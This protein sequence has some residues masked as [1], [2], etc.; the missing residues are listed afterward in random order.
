MY[1]RYRWQVLEATF[2]GY[3]MFYLVRNNLAVVTEDLKNVLHYD[4][5]MLGN[6]M[7]ATAI[8]Y[9]VGKFVMGAFSDRSN[10]RVFMAL[11]LLLT[12]CCNFAFGAV[13]DYSVHFWLW[14]LNGFFQGM[15]WPPC[16]RCMG[17]WFSERERGLTF[18]AWNTS[19]NLGGGVAGMLTAWSVTTFGGWEYAFYVPGALSL[20]GAGY[21]LWRLRDTPQSCGLPPVEEYR[22]D[23]TEHQREHGTLERDLSYK[24]LLVDNVLKHPYIW[25]LAFANFFAYIT[26]YSMLDWGPLYLREM[27]GA[28]IGEGGFAIFLIEFGGIPSTIFLG[29]L[30]DRLGGHR[31]MIATL[32][33]IPPIFAFSVIRLA[34][35]EYLSLDLAMLCI[36]GFC[37]YPVINL[38]TIMALDLTSKKAIGTAA[39]FIGLFGYLGKMTQATGFGNLLHYLEP[40]YGKEAAWNAVFWLIIAATLIGVALLGLTWRVRPKN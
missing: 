30:S 22:Q 1:P 18:S 12:A 33:L 2:F 38:I 8:S 17:H 6:I 26:R 32:A 35:P 20:L 34:P 11:G 23:L 4:K 36:I 16:G 27:K 29:W 24:E 9:G 19:H 3:A 21:L 37:I 13:Q 25:L 40:E 14:T 7:A 5:A 31:G 39:G 28:S 10:P 15:G